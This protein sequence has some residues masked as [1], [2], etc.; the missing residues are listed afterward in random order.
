MARLRS[1]SN[2]I[3]RVLFAL[4]TGLAVGSHP[5]FQPLAL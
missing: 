5:S 1:G 3:V 4:I 2:S